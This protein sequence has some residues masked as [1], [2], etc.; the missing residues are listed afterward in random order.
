MW[1]ELSRDPL[2][3]QEWLGEWVYGLSNHEQYV[4]K[5]GPETLARIK[6][7]AAPAGQIDYGAYR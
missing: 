3:V 4:R 7:G 5:L 6:P 2:R 1:D